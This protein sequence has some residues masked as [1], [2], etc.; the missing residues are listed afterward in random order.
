MLLKIKMFI[1]QISYA[2]LNRHNRRLLRGM[3]TCH[4]EKMHGRLYKRYVRG[5]ER[6]TNMQEKTIKA[7]KTVV[8][9][10]TSYWQKGR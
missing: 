5:I 3:Q 6:Q 1:Y 8:S 7:I 9:Q 10:Q 2:W 4:T